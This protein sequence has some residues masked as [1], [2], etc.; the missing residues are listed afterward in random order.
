MFL[1]ILQ[2]SQEN[3]YV[4]VPL[5][6]G[7]KHATLLKRDFGT[8]VFLWTCEIFKN[9]SGRLLLFRVNRLSDYYAKSIYIKVFLWIIVLW[10]LVPSKILRISKFVRKYLLQ[11]R[12][13]SSARNFTRSFILQ[14]LFY[15]FFFFKNKTPCSFFLKLITFNSNW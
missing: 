8:G 4:R 15:T 6:Q 3:T 7:L 9:T 14:D 2:N 1:E 11:V 13:R 12:C 10:I 5:C